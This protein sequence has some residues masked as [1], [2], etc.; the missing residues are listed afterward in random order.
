MY[1]KHLMN[2][3]E[4]MK[5]L[6]SLFFSIFQILGLRVYGW[7]FALRIRIICVDPY[8]DPYSGSQNQKWW[9]IFLFWKK[10]MEILSEYIFPQYLLPLNLGWRIYSQQ[11][12]CQESKIYILSLKGLYNNYERPFMQIWT[13][14]IHNSAI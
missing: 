6:K 2:H 5:L 10:G 4:I 7:Y 13:W 14:S 11:Q 8:T 3:S 1:S 12:V 9:K